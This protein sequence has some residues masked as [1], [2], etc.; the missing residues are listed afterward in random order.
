MQNNCKSRASPRTAAH[1]SA[2]G[3]GRCIDWRNLGAVQICLPLNRGKV[4]APSNQLICSLRSG[5]GDRK[6]QES[7]AEGINLARSDGRLLRRFLME[8]TRQPSRSKHQTSVFPSNAGFD[9]APLSSETTSWLGQ[10]DKKKTIRRKCVKLQGRHE[11]L[12]AG[13]TGRRISQPRRCFISG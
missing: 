11:S 10:T 4:E 1:T 8:P 12:S 3:R 2:P 5:R 9:P 13:R 6:N 7:L